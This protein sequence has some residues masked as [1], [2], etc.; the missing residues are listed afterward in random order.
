MCF[1]FLDLV[2]CIKVLILYITKLFLYEIKSI[3]LLFNDLKDSL[4]AWELLK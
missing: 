4:V 1:T 2:A 3:F